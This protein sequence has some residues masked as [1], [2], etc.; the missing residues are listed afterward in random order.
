MSKVRLPLE[1]IRVDGDKLYRLRTSRRITQAEAARGSDIT[2]RYYR[3]IERMGT[4]PSRHIA[5]DIAKFFGVPLEDF[6]VSTT[7]D[8]A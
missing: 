2:E 7:A 4:Q 5:E 8:A 3:G 6:C 1:G